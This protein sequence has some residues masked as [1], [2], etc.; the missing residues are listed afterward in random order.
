MSRISLKRS[1]V[2]GRSNIKSLRSSV[3]YVCDATWH[4]SQITGSDH[5]ETKDSSAFLTI[6][7]QRDLAELNKAGFFK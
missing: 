5:Y 7:L 1:K 4:I 2:R 6:F 3:T